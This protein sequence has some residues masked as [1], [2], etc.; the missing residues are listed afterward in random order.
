MSGILVI[1]L[2]AL[3]DVVMATALM[4]AIARHHAED[5][6]TLLTTPA[7]AGLFDGWSRW[8]VIGLPRKGWRDTLAMAAWVRRGRFARIYDLQANDRTA[9][10]CALSGSRERVGNHARFPYTH[11]PT[12]PW[13]GEGHIF[14]RMR[15]VLASAGIDDVPA[16]P[17]L[18]A[19]SASVARVAAWRASH[20]L[21]DG[22]YVVL[23]AGASARRPEKIWP[24]FAALAARLTAA[25]FTVVWLGGDEDRALN[26]AH[27]RL[28]GIDA[29]SA[30]SLVELAEVGR[31]AR[32]AVTNDSAPMHVLAAS[33]IPVFGLFGPSDWRRTHA[34]GQADNVIA[35]AP[36]EHDLATLSVDQVWLRLAAAGLTPG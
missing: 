32:F 30:L 23:H 28:C 18:P 29:S 5:Q 1:K 24:H 35:C 33:G 12:S 2:G 36:G 8:R 16:L 21:A 19:D 15:A 27:A 34:L 9:I 13:R 4:D 6:L 25:G 26:A 31:H 20:G 22:H 14:E 3:G 10:V 7:Y 11:H 17:V